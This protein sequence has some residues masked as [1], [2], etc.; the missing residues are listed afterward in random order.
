M[1]DELEEENVLKY[2]PDSD[3]D[4]YLLHM[5]YSSPMSFEGLMAACDGEGIQILAEKVGRD[6]LVSAMKSGM[7]KPVFYSGS[8]DHDYWILKYWSPLQHKYLTYAN[9]SDLE[10][11]LLVGALHTLWSV[12]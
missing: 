9:T 8:D 12:N 6:K 2:S 4:D 11:A 3:V 5:E 7:V 10:D 1:D